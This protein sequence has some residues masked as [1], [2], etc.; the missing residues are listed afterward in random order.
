[1]HHPLELDQFIKDKQ[2]R[3]HHAYRQWKRRSFWPGTG[4]HP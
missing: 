4:R 2:R 3:Y 1:M